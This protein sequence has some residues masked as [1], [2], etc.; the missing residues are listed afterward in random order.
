[1]VVIKSLLRNQSISVCLVLFYEQ[2][3]T[4]A[5]PQFSHWYCS[6][7]HVWALPKIYQRLHA[8]QMQSTEKASVFVLSTEDQHDLYFTREVL[9]KINSTWYKQRLVPLSL[10][11]Y[12]SVTLDLS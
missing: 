4:T 12:F 11:L 6:V 5:P 3:C 7:L 10:S 2:Y 8:E 9:I 1:M